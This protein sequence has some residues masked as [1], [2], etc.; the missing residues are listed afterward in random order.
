MISKRDKEKDGEGAGDRAKYIDNEK[1]IEAKEELQIGKGRDYT[2]AFSL[3]FC[4]D[5]NQSSD[6]TM[7]RVMCLLKSSIRKKM[8]KMQLPIQLLHPSKECQ[9]DIVATRLILKLK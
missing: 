8:D 7:L 2:E 3:G 1:V 6:H 4:P 5:M 9:L